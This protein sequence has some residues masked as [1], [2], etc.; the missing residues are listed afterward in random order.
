M[1][2][3]MSITFFPPPPLLFLLSLFFFLFRQILYQDK[4][5]RMPINKLTHTNQ[6][7]KH[8]QDC[9]RPH[10][11]SLICER[12]LTAKRACAQMCM[13]VCVLVITEIMLS[14]NVFYF[15]YVYFFLCRIL[16][17]LQERNE[18]NART[19]ICMCNRKLIKEMLEAINKW[20]KRRIHIHTCIHT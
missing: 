10:T 4:F 20:C 18:K 2:K 6:K 15:C 9:K 8:V 16:F 19:Y 14:A 17:L 13:Y 7:K 11:H 5:K 3:F 12:L 1:N